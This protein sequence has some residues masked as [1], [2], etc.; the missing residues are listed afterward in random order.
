MEFLERLFTQTGSAS[1]VNTAISALSAVFKVS[2]GDALTEWPMVSEFRAAINKKAPPGPTYRTTW[3]ISVLLKKVETFGRNESMALE[4]LLL[5]VVLLLRID[6]FARSS[7]VTRIFREDVIFHDDR[8]VLQFLRTKEW[9]ASSQIAWGE[10]S[11]PVTIFKLKAKINTCCYRTLA[12]WM[13]RTT[14]MV[15]SEKVRGRWRTPVVCHVRKGL[16]GK[17]VSAKHVATMSYAAMKAAGVDPAFKGRTIRAAASSAAKDYGASEKEVLC[18]GRWTDGKMWRKYYYR[19][20]PRAGGKIGGS[21]QQK[22]RA[23][24][25]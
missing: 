10:L 2:L 12:V 17:P 8:V 25:N 18:Q 6:C 1:S 15:R 11:A 23:G 20:I 3:D 24:L 19:S 13:N 5:K 22:I 9:R 21:L 4:L 14:E 16:M 7:D